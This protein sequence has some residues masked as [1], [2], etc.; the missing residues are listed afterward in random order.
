LTRHHLLDASALLAVIF[1]EP[2]AETVRDILDDC[3]IH[4]LNLA[5]A[6]RKLVDYGASPEDAQANVETLNLAILDG[7]GAE[8]AFE[9]ARLAPEAKRLGLSLGDCVCLTVAERHGAT[10]VTAD[11]AWGRIRGRKGQVVLIR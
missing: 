2:G 6:V 10:A 8:Q 4:A 11:R 5:E 7:F 9:I 1:E 3:E